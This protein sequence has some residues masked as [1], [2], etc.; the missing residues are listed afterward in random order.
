MNF[1]KAKRLSEVCGGRDNNLNFIRFVAALMVIFSHAFPLCLGSQFVD[2]LGQFSNSQITFGNLAVCVFFFYGGFLITT[3]VCRLRTGKKFFI[4]RCFRIFPP[5][6]VV[7]ITLTFVIGPLITAVS[8]KQYFVNNETYN[9]LLNIFLIPVH[10]LPGVFEN[11]SYNATVNG[12]LWTLPIE[13]LCYVLCFLF[14]KGQFTKE[15]NAKW[16]IPIFIIAFVVM[17]WILSGNELLA[18]ALRPIGLFYAGALY[19]VY[20]NKILLNNVAAFLAGVILIVTTK[21]G[22]L[23]WVIYLLFP[24]VLSYIGFSTKLSWGTLFKKSEISYGIYLVAWPIQQLLVQL[25]NNTMNPYVNFIV[26]IPLA[27]LGGYA[28]H[29]FVEVPML[30][31]SKK[32]IA[33]EK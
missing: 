15:K 5:L 11:N 26:T 28:I 12:P 21:F 25:T 9:Y 3:S 20:R 27:M 23:E 29:K 22:G 13:F 6:I 8:L 16:S 24:Y 2:P 1:F 17:K 32:L 7:T 19:Y 18:S 14:Y 4:A 31:F 10:T 33:K 30:V